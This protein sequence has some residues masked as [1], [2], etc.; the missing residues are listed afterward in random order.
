MRDLIDIMETAFEQPV[1][2]T[3]FFCFAPKQHNVVNERIAER[4]LASNGIDSVLQSVR[5]HKNTNS[6]FLETKDG[7]KYTYNLNTGLFEKIIKGT[8]N[9]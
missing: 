5:V 8:N 3:E 2:S 6:M 9:G 1:E 4:A 7:N